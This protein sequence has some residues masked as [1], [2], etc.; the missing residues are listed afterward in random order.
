[1][2]SNLI[3]PPFFHYPNAHTKYNNN[4]CA[5]IKQITLSFVVL[6][7]IKCFPNTKTLVYRY[8]CVTVYCS[9][10][11]V[12]WRHHITLC[13]FPFT[14]QLHKS[15]YI[16]IFCFHNHPNYINHPMMY[17]LSLCLKHSI[18]QTTSRSLSHP[19]SCRQYRV[20]YTD[21]NT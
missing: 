10:L 5:S 11:T 4:N 9:L 19:L 18:R 7:L 8:A 21:C 13:V 1:M 6:C 2:K 14:P 15:I 12:A 16:L 17:T 20:Q 3:D